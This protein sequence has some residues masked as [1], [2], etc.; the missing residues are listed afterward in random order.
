MNII[1]VE[2]DEAIRTLLENVLADEGYHVSSVPTGREALRLVHHQSPHLII[3]DL[4]M[5]H[6]DGPAF[7]AA[8]HKLAITHAPILLCTA[9]RATPAKAADLGAAGFLAKPFDLD[10]LLAAVRRFQPRE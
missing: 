2:D 6:M 8:Y 4:S 1:V 10:E 9:T 3:L 5:P 7:I